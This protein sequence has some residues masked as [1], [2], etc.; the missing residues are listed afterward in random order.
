MAKK[1]KERAGKIRIKIN[2]KRF[3]KI[4]NIPDLISSISILIISAFIL[5]LPTISSTNY[6]E[7]FE[8]PRFTSIIIV[9]LILG[10]LFF[11]R[12]K[13]F[14]YKS[15]VR[16]P[17][18]TSLVVFLLTYILASIFSL[19]P[20]TSITGTHGGWVLSLVAVACLIALTLMISNLINPKKQL[21][22]PAAAILLASVSHILSILISGLV[23]NDSLT[24]LIPKDPIYSISFHLLAFPI[25]MG[26]F[27]T[28]KKPLPKYF[29]LGAVVLQLLFISISQVIVAA[30]I[31]ILIFGYYLYK[32]KDK[33]LLVLSGIFLVSLIAM[34]IPSVNS[35]TSSIWET[36][37]LQEKTE[38]ASWNFKSSLKI[39]I[40]HPIT[41]VGPEMIHTQ[42]PKFKDEIN[43]TIFWDKYPTYSQSLFTQIAATT[44]I[45]G[46]TV[47]CILTYQIIR[48]AIRALF[49]DKKLTVAHSFILAT[50][51][52]FI[53]CFFY[54][55]TAV[56]LF[57]G[58]FL[59]GILIRQSLK[60]HREYKAT[61]KNI[62][63][64]L[65]ISAM[66][67]TFLVFMTLRYDF[68]EQLYFK[69][70]DQ[71]T[72]DSIQTINTAI[73]YN[74]L[75]PEYHLQKAQ[76]LVIF[77]VS[78][79]T[80][81]ETARQIYN[82]VQTAVALNPED[83]SIYWRSA[84]ILANVEN[85]YPGRGFLNL[86][87]TNLQKAKELNPN[88]PR[89]RNDLGSYY[90]SQNLYEKGL[91]EFSKSIN[92]K[93]DLWVSYLYKAET[94]ILMENEAE[95]IP[96]LTKVKEKSKDPIEVIIATDE[97]S[98]IGDDNEEEQ[99]E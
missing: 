20:I 81:E 7:Q 48:A 93:N 35:V 59:V 67:C 11:I 78:D 79:S 73:E 32:T 89:I 74:N 24:T 13:Y 88:D 34:R 94:Y 85:I 56:N 16:S 19:N 21:S 99:Q 41:G 98:R 61:P 71:S 28:L 60:N 10:C 45:I 75:E 86:A 14:S 66:V 96:L 3:P 95:A 43:D 17:V 8:F 50:P 55:M 2:P 18:L 31:V 69:S 26:L 37:P 42:L 91:D 83:F 30:I 63:P 27:L 9:T 53:L 51:I 65:G 76:Y 62:V 1:Q 44:G 36:R 46:L 49:K 33:L 12:S 58:A 4:K 77:L 97:L 6:A 47:L 87:V 22:L 82:E 29:T 90:V 64:T 38:L 15:F 5:A 54:N 68:A 57:I 80:P 40:D 52:W 84:Q 39:F 23:I 25:N 72:G 70:Q 92:L